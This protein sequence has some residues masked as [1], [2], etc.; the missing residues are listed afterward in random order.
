M[1]KKIIFD[2]NMNQKNSQNNSEQKPVKSDK[3]EKDEKKSETQKD[4]KITMALNFKKHKISK[5]RLD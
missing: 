4:N 2:L 1:K 5:D 3:E